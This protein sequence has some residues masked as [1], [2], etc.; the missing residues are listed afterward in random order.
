MRKCVLHAGAP[1]GDAPRHVYKTSFDV[2][3]LLIST[4]Y[5]WAYQ[6]LSPDASL[7]VDSRPVLRIDCG[8]DEAVARTWI[9]G[10]SDYAIHVTGVVRLT[11]RD[12][13]IR[14]LKEL[15]RVLYLSTSWTT[16]RIGVAKGI[17]Q[18]VKGEKPHEHDV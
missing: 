7:G 16:F 1:F 12:S 8:V 17:E 14:L 18:V 13:A 15:R 9:N 10:E 2:L 6:R 5:L 3:L 11:E 4:L